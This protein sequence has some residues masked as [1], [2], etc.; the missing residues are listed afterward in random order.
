LDVLSPLREFSIEE[1]Q[2]II[3]SESP[4][5]ALEKYPQID[6]KDLLQKAALFQEKLE[7]LGLDQTKEN[8]NELANI[9]MAKTATENSASFMATTCYD[10]LKLLVCICTRHMYEGSKLISCK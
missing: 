6:K 2:A 7:V 10:T 9:L 3:R 4:V 5:N 8:Q 1:L